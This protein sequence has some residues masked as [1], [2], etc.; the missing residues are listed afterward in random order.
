RDVLLLSASG[1]SR[2]E[3]A[4]Q[5]GYK[6]RTVKTYLHKAQKQ[7]RDIYHATDRV[8]EISDK[9]EHYMPEEDRSP[10]RSESVRLDQDN[11]SQV[12]HH[13]QQPSVPVNPDRFPPMLHPRYR[14]VLLLQGQGLSYTDIAKHFGITEGNVRVLLYRARQ[15]QKAL[16]EQEEQKSPP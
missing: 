3:I 13:Q 11:H 10:V 7:F 5:L 6:E 14:K 1:Y 2:A 12:I 4:Q 15:Q 16:I 8:R 9:Q